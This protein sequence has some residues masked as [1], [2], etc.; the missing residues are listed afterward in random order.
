VE[1]TITCVI[2]VHVRSD[3]RAAAFPT[4]FG[5]PALEATVWGWHANPDG[6]ALNN[7]QEYSLGTNMAVISDFSQA[8]GFQR[9]VRGG[10]EGIEVNFRK[11][12]DDPSLDYM[13][14]GSGDLMGWFSGLG[15]FEETSA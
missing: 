1:N 10:V 12:A 4:A 11:R 14:E 15:H 3:P 9:V 5:N 13:P 8:F 7:E 2:K 6:D